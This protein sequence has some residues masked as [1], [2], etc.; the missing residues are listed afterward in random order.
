MKEPGKKFYPA[1]YHITE[2]AVDL[3]S[4][5]DTNNIALPLDGMQLQ[6]NYDPYRQMI[7]DDVNGFHTK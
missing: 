1:I 5:S 2:K 4:I 7:I 6:G 3:V